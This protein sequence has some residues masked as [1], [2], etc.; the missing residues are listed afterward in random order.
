VTYTVAA[1]IGLPGDRSISIDD[2]IQVND[3]PLDQ[4]WISFS[5]GGLVKIVG[6]L[7]QE[8]EPLSYGLVRGLSG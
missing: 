3:Q 5:R 8:I 1:V 7:A 2:T 4:T 6:D